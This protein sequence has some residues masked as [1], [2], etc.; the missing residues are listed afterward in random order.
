MA[1]M[2]PPDKFTSFCVDLLRKVGGSTEVHV[3][4]LEGS[5]AGWNGPRPMRKRREGESPKSWKRA[6]AS[7]AVATTEGSISQQPA[8]YIAS[9]HEY[10]DPKH[11]IPARPFFSTMVRLKKDTWG[12]L[13]QLALKQH[14]YDT[15]KALEMVGLKVSE[16]LKD[17]ILHGGWE[18]VSPKTAARKGFDTPLVD[19]HNMLNAVDFVVT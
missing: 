4:F 12:K 3:G 8:A 17:S 18:A 19:S 14:N 11:N 7:Y 9:I 5:T 10:G 2:T 6:K 13:M 1:A 15:H 16:Q